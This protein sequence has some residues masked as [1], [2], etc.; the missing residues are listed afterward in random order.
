MSKFNFK[1]VSISSEHKNRSKECIFCGK[2]IKDE[3]ENNISIYFCNYTCYTRHA[4][5][6]IHGSAKNKNNNLEIH[7]GGYIYITIPK[8]PKANTNNKY[9]KHRHVIETE[10]NYHNDYF[11]FI[12]GFKILKSKYIVH[13]IDK[14]RLNNAIDNLAVMTNSE[15]SILYAEERD[16]ITFINVFLDMVS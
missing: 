8:H 11:D 13:H 14:D 16:V 12:D 5:G 15:H 3:T 6:Y 9:R 2:E 7:S 10:G 4:N 1:V